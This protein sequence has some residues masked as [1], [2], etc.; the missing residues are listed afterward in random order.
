[1]FVVFH[2][3]LRTLQ[4]NSESQLSFEVTGMS[5]GSDYPKPKYYHF[6]YYSDKNINNLI[7]TAPTSVMFYA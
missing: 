7:E 4:P 3:Q 1:M 2:V 6:N 5:P